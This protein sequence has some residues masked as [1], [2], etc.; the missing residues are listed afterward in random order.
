MY[1]GIKSPKQAAN[2]GQAIAHEI[3][4]VLKVGNLGNLNEISTGNLVMLVFDKVPWNGNSE[5]LSANRSLQHCPY[6]LKIA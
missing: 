2:R 5:I 3:V 1:V 6:G 4:S